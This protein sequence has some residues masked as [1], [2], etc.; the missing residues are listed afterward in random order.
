MA[1]A[2][3]VNIF[4]IIWSWFLPRQNPDYRRI[5]CSTS[6]CASVLITT[7]KSDWDYS[8]YRCDRCVPDE[9]KD[10]MKAEADEEVITVWSARPLGTTFPRLYF[11]SFD[12]L[13]DILQDADPGKPF[14][15]ESR[16]MTRGEYERLGEF[17]GW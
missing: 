4:D 5:P 17:P 1:V 8:W 9:E 15:I 14:E 3:Q 13:G 7:D 6:G 10:R 11:I 12:V 2:R 16:L